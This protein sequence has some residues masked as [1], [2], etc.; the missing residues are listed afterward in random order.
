MFVGYFLS[1]SLIIYIF[2]FYKHHKLIYFIEWL[3]EVLMSVK[4]FGIPQFD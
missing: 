2:D 3:R 1:A 4:P